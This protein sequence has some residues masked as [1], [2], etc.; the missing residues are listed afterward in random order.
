MV[1]KAPGQV[2]VRVLSIQGQPVNPPILVSDVELTPEL[3]VDDDSIVGR[4]GVSWHPAAPGFHDEAIDIDDRGE[5]VFRTVNTAK[6]PWVLECACGQLRHSSRCNLHKID[7]CH[8]CAKK[9]RHDYRVAW[10]RTKRK[11]SSS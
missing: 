2:D 4:N 5:V 1:S 7:K 11:S 6:K 8:V 3:E 10:Q 9:R